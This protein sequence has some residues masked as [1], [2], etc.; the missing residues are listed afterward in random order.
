MDWCVRRLPKSKSRQDVNKQPDAEPDSGVGEEEKISGEQMDQ[1]D[2]SPGVDETK[3]SEKKGGLLSLQCLYRKPKDAFG[4]D[5]L[6]L[7]LPN[8]D[9]SVPSKTPDGRF[10]IDVSSEGRLGIGANGY[11][12]RGWDTKL[13]IS[14]AVKIVIHNMDTF[15]EAAVLSRLNH[16][17]IVKLIDAQ[18]D[19]RYMYTV[20]EMCPGGELFHAIAA[21]PDSRL[22]EDRS[23]RLFLELFR[24]LSYLQSMGVSHCDIKPEN[25]LLGKRN[26]LKI[27]DFGLAKTANDASSQTARG[28][29]NRYAAPELYKGAPYDSMAA[30]MWSAGVVLYAALSGSFPFSESTQNCRAYRR[31]V[32][33]GCVWEGGSLPPVD[34]VSPKLKQDFVTPTQKQQDEQL[35]PFSF[36]SHFSSNV[37]NLIAHLLRP[38]AAQRC[39]AGQVLAHPF[40]ENVRITPTEKVATSPHKPTLLET[41][42]RCCLKRSKIPPSNDS[43]V[44]KRHEPTETVTTDGTDRQNGT[45][46]LDAGPGSP[47]K[48]H[49]GSSVDED[50]YYSSRF[51][52]SVSNSENDVEKPLIIGA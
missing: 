21:A 38:I 52:V 42:G 50:N 26:T 49:R 15:R 20:L 23:K 18:N 51:S 34:L 13:R 31:L 36:P 16:P 44:D 14:V 2:Y 24:G 29:S 8:A 12:Q 48:R 7:T 6:K 19:E 43:V 41:V 40:F 25:L 5:E 3:K 32:H 39:N 37:C 17:N 1:N 45:N 22:E 46:V 35:E 47:S 33:A 30:D 10:V 4:V 28:G 9:D 11:C 27:A